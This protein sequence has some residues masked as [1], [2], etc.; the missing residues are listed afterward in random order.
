MR[1]GWKPKSESVDLDFKFFC[2]T[3]FR[4]FWDVVQK[5]LF[6]GMIGQICFHTSAVACAIVVN[7][8]HTYIRGGVFCVYI[9]FHLLWSMQKDMKSSHVIMQQHIH[10]RLRTMFQHK[11]RHHQAQMIALIS[12]S[13]FIMSTFLLQC[14]FILIHSLPYSYYQTNHIHQPMCGEVGFHVLCGL[15]RSKPEKAFDSSFIKRS[16]PLRKPASDL[17]K[18]L[19]CFIQ[20]VCNV[21]I[22]SEMFP[23]KKSIIWF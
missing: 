11:H 13:I 10:T 3:S 8:K 7:T 17:G 22:V 18:K 23:G 16:E 6:F 12:P 9:I 21:L 20:W 14:V 1:C 5:A 4:A 2:Q 15:N 19:G